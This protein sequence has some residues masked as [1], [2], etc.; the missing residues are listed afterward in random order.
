MFLRGQ[1]LRRL[2]GIHEVFSDTE[3]EGVRQDRGPGQEDP[4]GLEAKLRS[5]RGSASKG[6]CQT[7]GRLRRRFTGG[8]DLDWGHC[9]TEEGGSPQSD[10]RTTGSVLLFAEVSGEPLTP[11]PRSGLEEV[12][13]SVMGF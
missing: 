4:G 12:K 7:I 2:C 5:G 10:L 9:G 11:D 13:V 6:F 3:A 1:S 8:A